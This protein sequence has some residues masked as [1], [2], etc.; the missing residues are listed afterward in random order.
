VWWLSVA[1][2]SVVVVVV[3]ELRERYVARH[4]TPPPDAVPP[5]G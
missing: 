1:V 3:P 4:A 5:H 2:T